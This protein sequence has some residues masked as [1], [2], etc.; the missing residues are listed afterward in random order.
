MRTHGIDPVGLA[1]SNDL[2]G[3]LST[4]FR[5]ALGYCF[6]CSAIACLDRVVGPVSAL[7]V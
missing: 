2:H 6:C 3:A 5:D 4:Q 7:D 1:C